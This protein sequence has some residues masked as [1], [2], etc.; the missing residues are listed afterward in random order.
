MK[1]HALFLTCA[2]LTPASLA[3]SLGDSFLR[4]LE[5]LSNLIKP[6]IVGGKPAVQ[7]AY[8]FYAI[9]G[10]DILCGATLIHPDILITAAHCKGAFVN[11]N[12][13]IGGNLFF[14]SDAVDTIFA[15][16]ERPHP[17]YNEFTNEHDLMLVKLSRP[18]KSPSVP[19]N[20]ERSLPA[21]NELVT[22]IGF[23]V[24]SDGGFQSYLL[25]E[26]TINVVNFSTCNFDYSGSIFNDS[27]ICAA[28][29]GKDSCQGDS[30]GPLL[31][32]QGR[33]VGV[34]SFGYGC[35]QPGEP[36]VYA[37]VSSGKDFIEQGICDLSS[38]PPASCGGT[39]L[40]PK[41]QLTP[42]QHKPTVSPA[43]AP[44]PGTTVTSGASTV[45]FTPTAAPSFGTLPPVDLST[46]ETC[47]S[48]IF[49]GV[50]MQNMISGSCVSVCVTLAPFI[51]VSAG[52]TCGDCSI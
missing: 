48:W 36:G 33:L 30:G 18:S 4:P 6:R 26:V 20:V 9:P 12:V 43:S 52:W 21:D 28:A 19:I 17:S 8:P 51:W 10:G 24:T 25:R 49:S 34:V 16:Q 5:M 37:R 29:A 42:I 40:P 11:G 44:S 1:L 23:G 27:M 39:T 22:V 35:A 45:P 38:V 13:Y 2:A 7:G 46:C 32:Q 41:I 15:T 3:S 50:A 31:D 47:R 14:G